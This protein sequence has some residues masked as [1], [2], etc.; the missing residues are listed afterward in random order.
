[1]DSF[2]QMKMVYNDHT[3]TY[4]LNG[5]RTKSAT[6]VAKIAA[7]SYSID[8]WER[9][10]VAIGMTL[11]PNLVERVAVDPA[12]RA[13]VQQVCEDAK[14]IAKANDASR[15]GTQRHRA[16]ELVDLDLPMLTDQQRADAKAWQR[17]LERYDIEILPEFVEGFVVWP[18]HGVCGRFDRYAR[19]QG[20][21]VCLDLKSGANAVTYPQSTAA[22]LALYT[23]APWCS[24]TAK[25]EGDRTTVTEWTRPPSDL[26]I[27]HGYVILLGDDADV[28]ELWK[29]DIEHG[30]HGANH[31]LALSDWRKM[32][33]GQIARQEPVPQVDLWPWKDLIR[34]A[35]T[36]E[37]LEDIW[38][39]ASE[40]G[41]WEPALTELA[42]RAKEALTSLATIEGE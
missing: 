32:G 18:D 33:A 16:A 34:D 2:P 42:R 27:Q 5:R 29:I 4:M 13:A 3:H 23:R 25:T 38:R 19:Y 41:Q 31:A 40:A 28:G 26:D 10:Q 6:A 7:D 24:A 17:T 39:Q 36:T 37:A 8:M 11:Q 14:E 21:T 9:R 12:N 30:W 35:T 22:Q 15:R 1:M 20:R